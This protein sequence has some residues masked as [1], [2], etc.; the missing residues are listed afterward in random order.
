MDSSDLIQDV[1][2]LK[3]YLIGLIQDL[4]GFK[5]AN[6]MNQVNLTKIKKRIEKG[7]K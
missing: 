2:G 5:L 7:R 1:S 3:Q 4:N 6:E